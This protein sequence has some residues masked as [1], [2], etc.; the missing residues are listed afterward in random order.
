MSKPAAEEPED[1]LE[2][3]YGA[4]VPTKD[5]KLACPMFGPLKDFRKS[6]RRP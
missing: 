5:G 6:L 3:I 1:D 4:L 2:P